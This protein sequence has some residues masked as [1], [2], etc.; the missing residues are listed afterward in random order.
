M[1]LQKKTETLAYLTLF[2]IKA[3]S[4]KTAEKKP[5]MDKS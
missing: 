5:R 4:K 1:H 2:N 3:G